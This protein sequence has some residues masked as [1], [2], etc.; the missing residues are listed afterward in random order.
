MASHGDGNNQGQT[1][2]GTFSA[3]IF[4]GPL[5][6]IAGREL[7]FMIDAVIASSTVLPKSRPRTLYL[8]AT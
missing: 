6:V 3:S 7:H 5:Q 1:R 2:I 4:T 8:I